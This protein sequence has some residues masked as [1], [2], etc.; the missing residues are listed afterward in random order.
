MKHSQWGEIH[1]KLYQIKILNQLFSISSNFF[2]KIPR[3]LCDLRVMIFSVDN[4]ADRRRRTNI[5]KVFELTYVWQT[6]TAWR[7]CYLQLYLQEHYRPSSNGNVTLK[8]NMLTYGLREPMLRMCKI[9]LILPPFSRWVVF[10][11]VVEKGVR[12]MC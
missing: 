12:P 5:P 1:S 10:H 8:W 4:S 2:G 6:N 9:Y 7:L 11:L 3:K